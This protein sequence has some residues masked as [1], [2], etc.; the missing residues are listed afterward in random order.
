MTGDVMAEDALC[1]HQPGTFQAPAAPTLEYGAV[2]SD[3]R[4]ARVAWDAA[5]ETR[6]KDIPGLRPR[7]GGTRRVEAYC[8]EKGIAPHHAGDPL[9]HPFAHAD[10]E[11]LRR[12]RQDKHHSPRRDRTREPYDVVPAPGADAMCRRAPNEAARS[13]IAIRP[14]AELRNAFRSKPRPSSRTSSCSAPLQVESVSATVRAS[15]CRTALAS[16]SCATR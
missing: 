9:R 15:A 1:T 14:R 7:H 16:A 10:P 6:M 12:A 8:R 11:A 4:R 3:D 13:S 2:A 5:A